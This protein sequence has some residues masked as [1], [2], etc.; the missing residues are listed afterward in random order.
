MANFDFTKRDSF[1]S[2][3]GVIA[4]AAG[5]AI[6]LG[7]I[8]RFPYIAGENG[9]GAF[10]LVYLFFI[11]VIGVPVMLSEFV[12][13]RSA[14][15]NPLGA[16]KL[17]APKTY[18]FLV[19]FLGIAAAFFI[20]AFYTTVSGWTLEYLYLALT[21]GF[22]GMGADQMSSM[23]EQF[24]T[25][26]MRP[27][28]WQ[29]IFMFLTAFIVF[30][31]IKNGIEKYTK[32][33][34]PALLLI[35]IVLCIRAITLPGGGEGLVFL[36]KPDFSK[37]TANGVMQALGQSFFSLSIGMGALIT[38]GSYISKKDNLGVTA[39]SVTAADLLIAILAGIAIF[40]AVFAFGI[41][42]EAG[43]GL[44]FI[45]LPMIFQQMTGGYF[46][47]LIFFLLLSIA[48]LTSTISLLEVVVA[49]M[50]EELNINR[51]KSTVIGAF[52]I[53]LLG[54][55][56]TL[57]QGPMPGLRIG[58]R[59]LFDLL[60]FSSANIMLPVGG[61]LIVIFAGWFMGVD[62]VFDELSNGGKLNARYK[63]AFLFIIRFIAPIGIALV[64]LNGIGILN[65]FSGG[66]L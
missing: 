25:S 18:W 20:L 50:S 28:V 65:F 19:G 12:I 55:F 41:Q 49:Y 9:G 33:L 45:T 51:K 56:C 17:L 10:L 21:N 36:F 4:A 15:R 16:L 30:R 59:N 37:L 5:S 22:Q 60:D 24:R 53:A 47:S 58:E 40:P 31:G 3:M 35:I 29:A 1:G 57:S 54:V 6:G 62:K 8:W 46:F 66:D 11:V 64:F 34:M 42:P 48:A 44:V 61:L 39:I 7:N 23:F 13:G 2:K 26:G 52:S 32:I 38:Y 27:L 63:H 14:Q 43:P